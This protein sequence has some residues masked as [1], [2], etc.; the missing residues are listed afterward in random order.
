MNHFERLVR[1]AQLLPSSSR[2]LMDPF[3]AEELEELEE[4]AMLAP[5][6]SAEMA[7]RPT[8]PPETDELSSEAMGRQ[9]PVLSPPT[10]A[11]AVDRL[12][13]YGESLAPAEPTPLEESK[14]LARV[15]AFMSALRHSL[16]H[17][18][19]PG[20]SRRNSGIRPPM[21]PM[22]S[23]KERARELFVFRTPR[24]ARRTSSLH[25]PI[26]GERPEGSAAEPSRP[27]DPPA[28]PRMLPPAE[29]SSAPMPQPSE[30]RTPR[31]STPGEP[32]AP[33]PAP[34]RP[35]PGSQPPRIVVVQPSPGSGMT[36]RMGSGSRRYGLGQM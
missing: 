34:D 11:P 23:E 33:D 26:S 21:G 14:G 30:A 18:P 29:A 8:V 1:R 16:L 2:R 24:A 20:G 13:T 36:E 7:T 10:L 4:A 22:P 6:E 25:G 31:T 9:A 5:S 12:P 17:E 19:L 35:T 15:D 3:E 28:A 32:A 27:L